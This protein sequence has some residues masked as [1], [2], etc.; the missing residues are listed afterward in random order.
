MPHVEGRNKSKASRDQKDALGGVGNQVGIGKRANEKMHSYKKWMGI[1][2]NGGRRK[3]GETEIKG[4]I[5]GGVHKKPR[6]SMGGGF[7]E[8][9][10]L[11]K[12]GI[13]TENN[14]KGETTG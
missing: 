7:T 1:A 14:I 2:K 9:K 10:R 11:W 3:R 6:P 13:A 12:L 5:T 4:E 8:E